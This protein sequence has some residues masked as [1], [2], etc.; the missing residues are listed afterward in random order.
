MYGRTLLPTTVCTYAANFSFR[1][2]HYNYVRMYCNSRII[3][4][5]MHNS[6]CLPSKNTGYK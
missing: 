5:Y 3:T 1:Y 4:T 6:H 2:V